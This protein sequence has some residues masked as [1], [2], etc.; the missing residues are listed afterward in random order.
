MP[1]SVNVSF[2]RGP[3]SRETNSAPLSIAPQVPILDELVSFRLVKASAALPI[4][5][6]LRATPIPASTRTRLVAVHQDQQ[7]QEAEARDLQIDRQRN[8]R[9]QQQLRAIQRR[10]RQHVEDRQVEAQPHAVDQ[11]LRQRR[12]SNAARHRQDP[13]ITAITTLLGRSGQRHQ[14]QPVQ[15]APQLGRLGVDRLAPTQEAAP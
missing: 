6:P 1:L 2:L 8:A 7:Q 3:S 4:S 11:E 5:P 9:R 13:R 15:P 14:Q 12:R 10:H